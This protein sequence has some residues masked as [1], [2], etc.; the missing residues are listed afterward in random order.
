M[1]LLL[2]S[3][4]FVAFIGREIE[5]AHHLTTHSQEV[6]SSPESHWIT[7]TNDFIPGQSPVPSADIESDYANIE[8]SAS[9][10]VQSTIKNQTD[11]SSTL[12]TLMKNPNIIPQ[13]ERLRNDPVLWNRINAAQQNVLSN[14]PKDS[15]PNSGNVSSNDSKKVSTTLKLVTNYIIS[16]V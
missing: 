1:N 16:S 12:A 3:I 2:L 8:Q 7:N 13:L 14:L 4:A 10:N 5:S 11:L 15:I 9:S 6:Q